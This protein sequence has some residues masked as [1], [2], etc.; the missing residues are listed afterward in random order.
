M[1]VVAVAFE[2]EDAVN[3]VLEH[4]GAGDGPLLRH[5]T[6]EEECYVARL[7]HPQQTRGRL[8]HLRYGPGAEPMS[9]E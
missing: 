6:D 3:Q 2:L 5:V 8:S 7:G 9:G 1:S 4:P